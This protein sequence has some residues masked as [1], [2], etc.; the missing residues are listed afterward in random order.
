[1]T[2]GPVS[3]LT[4]TRGARSPQGPVFTTLP[5]AGR[6]PVI[7]YQVQVPT[8]PGAAAGGRASTNEGPTY[9]ANG[10]VIGSWPDRNSRS[11]ACVPFGP[12]PV[13]VRGI[14]PYGCSDMSGNLWEWCKDRY[15]ANYWKT[16][17]GPDPQGPAT[18]ADRAQRGGS[19]STI[20]PV[21]FRSAYRGHSP[22][23]DQGGGDGFRCASPAAR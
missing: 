12:H 16:D 20:V 17:H 21:R 8:P 7:L 2:S 3:I 19:N 1:L 13:G 9:L 14:S 18:G 6:V 4:S 5:N 22:P 10:V 15:D 23:G 11:V